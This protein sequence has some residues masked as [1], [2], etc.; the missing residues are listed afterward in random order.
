M[1]PRNVQIQFTADPRRTQFISP[2]Q[3][4]CIR[5]TAHTLEFL[6]RRPDGT[7]RVVI[8]TGSNLGLLR[9]EILAGTVHLLTPGSYSPPNTRVAIHS[10]VDSST[11]S[12]PKET[13]A[14]DPNP[15]AKTCL[16]FE[17]G[18]VRDLWSHSHLD[19]FALP[20]RKS[21]QFLFQFRGEYSYILTAIP[22][23]FL[24]ILAKLKLSNLDPGMLAKFSTI[25]DALPNLPGVAHER[26]RM[27]EIL[28]NRRNYAAE[29]NWNVVMDFRP[30]IPP[31]Q[32]GMTI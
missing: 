7:F 30:H 10:I 5:Q 26:Y 32:M 15:V 18:M 9:R 27:K 4:H 31:P 14:P 3:L 13:M 25:P 1:P 29:S 21:D 12:L 24:D 17:T 2:S 20:S 16:Q 19:A 6:Y 11:W 28:F 23:T 22:H 8:V